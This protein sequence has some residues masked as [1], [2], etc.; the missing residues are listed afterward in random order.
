M[1]YIMEGHRVLSDTHILTLSALAHAHTRRHTHAHCLALFRFLPLQNLA[2]RLLSENN[3]ASTSHHHSNNYSS[4]SSLSS[5]GCACRW[6]NN[7]ILLCQSVSHL[8]A[9]HGDRDGERKKKT[10]KK[11]T[12]RRSPWFPSSAPPWAVSSLTAT[13]YCSLTHVCRRWRRWL[14]Q[15]TFLSS[16]PNGWRN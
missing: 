10:K 13:L 11:N 4:I 1:I 5:P 7:M 2:R 6:I 9:S 16:F 14:P 12:S 3:E 15:P 8:N